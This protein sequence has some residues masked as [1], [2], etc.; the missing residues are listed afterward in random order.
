M[1]KPKNPKYKSTP[2]MP[3]ASASTQSWDNFNK[4]VEEVRKHNQKL[5][6]EFDKE[7]KAFNAEMKKRA[8]IK[9]KARKVKSF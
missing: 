2:K 9:E 3:K 5:K 7:M 6:S 8:T 1:K 4:K